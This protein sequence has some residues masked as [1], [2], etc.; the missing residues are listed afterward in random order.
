MQQVRHTGQPA[1]VWI[2]AQMG[3]SCRPLQGFALLHYLQFQHVLW[4]S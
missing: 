4:L 3:I 2:A 1:D